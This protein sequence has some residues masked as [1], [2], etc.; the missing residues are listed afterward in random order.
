MQRTVV[1]VLGEKI[2]ETT[3]AQAKNIVKQNVLQKNW[4]KI[5]KHVLK[6]C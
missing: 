4:A 1:E 3:V 6:T 2:A 5:S